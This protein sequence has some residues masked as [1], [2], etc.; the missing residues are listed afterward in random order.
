MEALQYFVDSCFWIADPDLELQGEASEDDEPFGVPG[1]DLAEPATYEVV[2]EDCRLLLVDGAEGKPRVARRSH[3]LRRS[4]KG[5]GDKA[6]GSAVPV[7]QGQ[8][9]TR[10]P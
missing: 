8:S 2:A 3:V 9:G 1:W 6:M 10:E 7:D 5:L 4:S